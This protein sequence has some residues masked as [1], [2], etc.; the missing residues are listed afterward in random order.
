MP[1][2]LDKDRQPACMEGCW[3]EM[4]DA[5]FAVDMYMYVCR[6]SRLAV[7]SAVSIRGVNAMSCTRKPSQQTSRRRWMGSHSWVVV[8][9]YCS[10]VSV[11]VVVPPT[12]VLFISF[13]AI[14]TVQYY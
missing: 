5:L 12:I 8:R 4:Q 1:I 7:C 3:C 10:G 11:A 6:L 14:G 9:W 13:E 2:T